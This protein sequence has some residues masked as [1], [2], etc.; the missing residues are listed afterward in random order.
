MQVPHLATK[1]LL[2]PGICSR[3]VQIILLVTAA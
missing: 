2:A 1:F 3:E